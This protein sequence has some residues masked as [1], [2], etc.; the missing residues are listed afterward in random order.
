LNPIVPKVIR[1]V[2]HD[3]HVPAFTHDT[4]PLE[5]TGGQVPAGT[6][7]PHEKPD[8][9][10]VREVR[11]GESGLEV[12]VVDSLGRECYDIT[13]SR[14]EIAGRHFYLLAPDEPADTAKRWTAGETSSNANPSQTLPWTRWWLPAEQAHVLAAGM[15][16]QFGLARE[17]AT[18]LDR[19]RAS[20]GGSRA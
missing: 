8:H 10:A 4:I 14:Y 9:A 11:G 13:P 5:T 1:Y 6:I 18:A 15:G 17:L 19:S 2:V 12:R 16:A 7:E 3:G 20:A